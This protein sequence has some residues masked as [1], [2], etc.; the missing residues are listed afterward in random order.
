MK[1]ESEI[2]QKIID[3][4]ERLSSGHLDIKDYE[5]IASGIV[6]LEAAS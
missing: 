1:T 2:K 4:R 3:S 6:A 5:D